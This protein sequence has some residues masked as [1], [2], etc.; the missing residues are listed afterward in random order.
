MVEVS[1]EA[2]VKEMEHIQNV[3]LDIDPV[4]LTE[5]QHWLYNVYCKKAGITL[6]HIEGLLKAHVPYL[7]EFNN[8][9]VLKDF[10][11]KNSKNKTATQRFRDDC[12]KANKIANKENLISLL[13]F[14][15]TVFHHFY[16][17]LRVLIDKDNEFQIQFIDESLNLKY[18]E[19]LEED[20]E[21]FIGF[22]PRIKADYGGKIGVIKLKMTKFNEYDKNVETGTFIIN[23]YYKNARIEIFG[24][25]L[26]QD[27]ITYLRTRRRETGKLIKATPKAVVPD[28]LH[29][30]IVHTQIILNQNVDDEYTRRGL[31]QSVNRENKYAFS[32]ALVL[33][34][35]SFFQQYHF[36]N[37]NLNDKELFKLADDYEKIPPEITYF[38]FGQRINTY[39]GSPQVG[40]GKDDLPYA[41]QVAY[42]KNIALTYQGFYLSQTAN[43]VLIMNYFSLQI[44][45]SG[46]VELISKDGSASGQ[47]RYVNKRT[48]KLLYSL[49]VHITTDDN[50]M[51]PELTFALDVYRHNDTF[52][53]KGLRFN[54]N[55]ESP[56]G[57]KIILKSIPNAEPSIAEEEFSS[58]NALWNAD[59]EIQGF[60]MLNR[61]YLEGYN[62]FLPTAKVSLP[63]F[64][65]RQLC[66]FTI[67]KT[68]IGDG[69]FPEREMVI[70]KMNFRL[71]NRSFEIWNSEMSCKQGFPELKD[72]KMILKVYSHQEETF[73]FSLK[74]PLGLKGDFTHAFGTM[75]LFANDKPECRS[76]VLTYVNEPSNFSIYTENEIFQVLNNPQSDVNLSTAFKFLIGNETNRLIRMPGIINRPYFSK[77]SNYKNDYLIMVEG[78]LTQLTD[79]SQA[80]YEN[81]LK[82]VEKTLKKARLQGFLVKGISNNDTY[83]YDLK[84]YKDLKNRI[85]DVAFAKKLDSIFFEQ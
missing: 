66:I 68:E 25:W 75:S 56:V 44:S 6:N 64:L 37:K 17:N 54:F 38:L 14:Y 83:D 3:L 74:R 81:T 26:K 31:I 76:A 80:N 48:G 45:A 71:K 21:E 4:Q 69:D 50:R 12:T 77:Y 34:Q 55:Q 47:V 22:Y 8:K 41:E 10:I 33:M 16:D 20:I 43:N 79:K 60:F 49:L 40:F 70:M 78:L 23:S 42:I 61:G 82:R 24:R 15:W 46:G 35:K 67:T 72:D 11:L 73:H 84:Y 59:E 63:A 29:G 32:A 58:S 52:Y 36:G 85:A 9:P 27:N 65:D 18:P 39:L 62:V 5:A 51:L 53:M 2:L 30:M 13:S 19:F 28:H 7:V 1:Y 57:G